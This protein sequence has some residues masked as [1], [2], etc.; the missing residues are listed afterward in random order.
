M[1][2]TRTQLDQGPNGNPS[3]QGK[4][5]GASGGSYGTHSYYTT[6]GN[7]LTSYIRLHALHGQVNAHAHRAHVGFFA[8]GVDVGM[9]RCEIVVVIVGWG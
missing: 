2:G 8:E 5:L 1:Y 4:P 7:P 6:D 9:R 3:T